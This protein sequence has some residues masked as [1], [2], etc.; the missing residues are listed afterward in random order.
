MYNMA[1]EKKKKKTTETITVIHSFFIE[2]H[3]Y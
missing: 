2:D 1:F 3:T